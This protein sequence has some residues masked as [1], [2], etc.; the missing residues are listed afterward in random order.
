M[1]KIYDKI[2]ENKITVIQT[3]IKYKT[4]IIIKMLYYFGMEKKIKTFFFGFH[5]RSEYYVKKFISYL[6]G[7]DINLVAKYF[8]PCT[9]FAKGDFSID[10]N[11]FIDAIET[12]QKSSIIMSSEKVSNE[13]YLTYL[14]NG[15]DE[16]I[17]IVD[18]L[19]MLKEKCNLSIEEIFKKM[20]ELSKDK[21]II[22]FLKS[23]NSGEE[24]V[25]YVDEFIYMDGETKRGVEYVKKN[26][27]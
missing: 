5:L 6:T 19:Y 27:R 21:K 20:K 26:N 1:N 8:L 9:G 17:I 16:E 23:T 22:L 7:I 4:Q 14:F 24:Y 11:K 25:D 10:R 15:Y 2:L 13:D 18:D 3:N 12:L